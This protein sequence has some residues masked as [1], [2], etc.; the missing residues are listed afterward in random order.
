MRSEVEILR[1]AKVI[2]VVGASSDPERPAYKVPRTVMT[3][4]YTIIPV[5]PNETEVLGQKAYPTLSDVPVKV[6]VVNIFRRSEHVPAVVDEAIAIGAGAIWMQLGVEHEE[7]AAKARARG[8]EVVM[9]RCI[10]C[11]M[12]EH[13]EELQKG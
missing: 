11:A 4:G 5:N 10:E 7:A 12:R 3:Y 8:I 1:Q 6:D 2:A 9:N 13:Q